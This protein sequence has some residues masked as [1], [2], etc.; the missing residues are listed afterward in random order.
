MFRIENNTPTYEEAKTSLIDLQKELNM[1]KSNLKNLMQQDKTLEEEQNNIRKNFEINLSNEE[2]RALQKYTNEISEPFSK[3]VDLIEKELE[4]LTTKFNKEL[5]GLTEDHL[6]DYYYDKQ[7]MLE[8]MR[9]VLDILNEK[10]KDLLGD[11]FLNE[12]DNQVNSISIEIPE[13]NLEEICN[14]F[15]KESSDLEKIKEKDNKILSIEKIVGKVNNIGTILETGNKQL[16]LIVLVILSIVFYFAFKF[17][18]PVYVLL[19]FLYAVYNVKLSNKIRTIYIL[20]KAIQDN[21]NE[22][23]NMYREKARIQLEEKRNSVQEDYETKKKDLEQELN[24]A[25][26]RLQSVLLSAKERFNFNDSKLKNELNDLLLINNNKRK[27]LQIQRLREEENLKLLNQKYLEA[28]EQF[29]LVAMGIKN[30][31]LGYDRIGTTAILDNKFLID[32]DKITKKPK[33]WQFN[34][35]SNLILYDNITDV[36][37]FIKL[38]IVQ[39]RTKLSP[40]CLNVSIYDSAFMCKD[41]LPFRDDSNENIMRFLISN[42]QLKEYVETLSELSIARINT[43]KKEFSNIID[44]NQYMMNQ[45]SIPESYTFFFIQDPDFNKILENKFTQILLN[46]GDLGIYFLLFMSKKEF[47]EG[48]E[49]SLELIKYCS[50]IFSF[51]PDTQSDYEGSNIIIKARAKDYVKDRMI[52]K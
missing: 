47:Y 31:Y 19:L 35:N 15:D 45:D 30:E 17:V 20:R 14:Y 52:E 6:S 39:L 9:K 1:C 7:E 24:E 21:I 40:T 3:N 46:G 2:I 26:D 44:Y 18:F 16:I 28:K 48:K 5:E 34:L 49:Q 38:I 4:D 37:N 23:E 8:E 10:I 13:E 11:R 51:E 36:I 29:N 22:I 25:N 42:D 27:R 33:F 43:I 50:K 41:Y 32:I 12:L